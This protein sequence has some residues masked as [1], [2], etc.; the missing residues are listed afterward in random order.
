M[1]LVLVL[2]LLLSSLGNAQQKPE[3]ERLELVINAPPGILVS[4]LNPP[5]LKLSSPFD[6]AILKAKVSGKPWRDKPKV[7]Y[8]ELNPVTWQLEVPAGTEPGTYQA[9]LEANFSLCSLVRGFC[10]TTQQ[11]AV[12]TV[13]VGSPEEN[14]PVVLTLSQPE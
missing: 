11:D 13:H 6:G 5:K 1:K 12:F 2:T 10:F 7:Y 4:R 3:V 8:A 9:P 14:A